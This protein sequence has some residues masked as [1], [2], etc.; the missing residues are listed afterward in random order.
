MEVIYDQCQMKLGHGQV[1]TISHNLSSKIT[2]LHLTLSPQTSKLTAP[3]T[4][5]RKHILLS[6]KSLGLP[7][8]QPA[9][10][11]GEK[12]VWSSVGMECTSS[13]LL[14]THHNS[15]IM[16]PKLLKDKVLWNFISNIC[17]IF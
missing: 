5:G 13:I 6:F 10:R 8:W 7:I 4:G 2:S 14:L 15:K 16:T 1:S 9:E 12:L 17:H 11:V 3:G